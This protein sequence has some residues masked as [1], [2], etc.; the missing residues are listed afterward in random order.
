MK[1]ILSLLLVALAVVFL[2]CK[3]DVVEDRL[4]VNATKLSFAANQGSKNITIYSS[5]DWSAELENKQDKAWCAITPSKGQAGDNIIVIKVTNNDSTD[6]RNTSVII[7][8]PTQQRKVEIAQDS[9]QA[10]VV[11]PDIVIDS[12]QQVVEI[13]VRA[14]VEYRVGDPSANWLRQESARAMAS[15]TIRYQVDANEDYNSRAA[16]ISVESNDGLLKETVTITQMQKDAIVLAQESYVIGSE[17]G[18]IEIEVGH[19]VEFDVEIYDDWI[20]QAATRAFAT[21]RLTFSIAQN[22]TDENREGTITFTSKD[23]SIQQSVTV[24]QNYDSTKPRRNEIWYTTVDGN[25]VEPDT[26]HDGFG[27]NIISN[28]YNDGKGVITFDGEVTKIGVN[29][30]NP[31]YNLVTVTIP[32]SVKEIGNFAFSMSTSGDN[33]IEV[34]LGN[35]LESIGAYAFYNCR[36]LTDIQLP[37]GLKSINH[38]AFT[39]C[40][41][42]T[43][44]TIPDSVEEIGVSAFRCCDNIAA[45]YGKF[46]SADHRYLSIDGTLIAFACAG[47]T[48]YTI[49]DDVTAIGTEAFWEK[50][51]TDIVIPQSV[52]NIENYAFHDCRWLTQITLPQALTT[53]EKGVFSGCYNLKSVNIPE[54]VTKIGENAFNGCSSLAEITIPDKVEVIGGNAFLGCDNLKKIYCKPVTPPTISGWLIFDDDIVG[55]II[56]VPASSVDTYKKTSRWAHYA[57]D[58]VGY[59]F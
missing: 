4:D 9:K 15:Q 57:D 49:P 3:K 28:T 18:E 11:S 40:I 46:A 53:I 33:L 39:F 16:T 1:R 55:R 38:N 31:C 32:D 14:N 47:L 45:F 17:G 22:P 12:K 43:S 37:N 51:L 27:A 35:G 6:E 13:E 44:I 50:Y 52:V 8:T 19:N 7:K 58:I 5:D 54:K 42:L 34:V 48:S 30:F 24:L 10:I 29:A 59:N 23:K 26:Q 36:K 56:Y 2:S 41:N 20:S 25:I 21:E